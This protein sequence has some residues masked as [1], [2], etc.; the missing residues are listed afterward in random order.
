MPSLTLTSS[1]EG[2]GQVHGEVNSN[3]WT[4]P[5]LAREVRG[6]DR[7]WSPTEAAAGIAD[8]KGVTGLGFVR[9]SA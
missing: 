4:K 8:R 5:Y 9:K 1:R 6:K 3:S 7:H 2:K